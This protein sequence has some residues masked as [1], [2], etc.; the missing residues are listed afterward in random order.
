MDMDREQVTVAEDTP[1]LG[2]WP[3][4]VEHGSHYV[5]PEPEFAKGDPENP[6]EWPAAF[7]WAITTLLAC[8]A[9]TV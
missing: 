6:R 1:L 9:F 2:N 7:K 4:D 5:A 8:M 3:G